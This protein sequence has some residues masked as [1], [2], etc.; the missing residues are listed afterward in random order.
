MYSQSADN[1]G[2]AEVGMVVGYGELA[3]GAGYCG[4]AVSA[5][6][7]LWLSLPGRREEVHRELQEGLAIMRKKA[8]TGGPR[9]KMAE[10]PGLPAA[11]WL[12]DLAREIGDYF[13]GRRV[14]LD[15][16]VDFSLYTEF[17]RVVLQLVR[18]IPYGETRTYGQLAA[19]AGRPAA[20]RAVGQVLGANRVL[21]VVPC[22]RVLAAQ[23]LGGFGAGLETKRY[24][25]S[26]EG[27]EV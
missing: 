10:E 6:G 17:Q 23:G 5:K 8:A 7:L 21:L 14:K 24:L 15:Y 12:D 25:L 18:D 2:P 3:T 16:P 9:L 13:A 1:G 4:V 20:S 11:A 19:L 26:L 22:H 27:R